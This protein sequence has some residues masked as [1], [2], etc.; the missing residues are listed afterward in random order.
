MTEHDKIDTVAALKRIKPGTKLKLVRNLR[1]LQVGQV[2]VFEKARSKDIV[3]RI[4][5]GRAH[6]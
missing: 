1:G 3:F 5:I 6:V 2:R 4:E